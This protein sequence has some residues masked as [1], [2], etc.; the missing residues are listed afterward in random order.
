MRLAGAAWHVDRAA[1][2]VGAPFAVWIWARQAVQFM[3]D[4][5]GAPEFQLQEAE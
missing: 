4:P 3:D 5:L 1:R 2:G